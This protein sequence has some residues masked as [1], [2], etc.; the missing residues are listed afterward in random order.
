MT[1]LISHVLLYNRLILIAAVCGTLATGLGLCFVTPKYSAEAIV[2]VDSRRDKLADAESAVS[3]IVVDQYQT[4]LKSELAMITSPALARRV[5]ISLHLLETPEFK[6]AHTHTPTSHYF[7]SLRR[8]LVADMEWVLDAVGVTDE[9]I[10]RAAPQPSDI[11]PNDATLENGAKI[12]S[13]RLQAINDAKSLTLRISYES[14][15]PRLAAAVANAV[16]DGYLAE[17]REM[18]RA[19]SARSAAWLLKRITQ[20]RA[21]LETAEQAVEDFRAQHDLATRERAPLQDELLQLNSRRLDAEG[22]VS[23]AQAKVVQADPA[24]PNSLV[25]NVDV[26]NSRMVAGLLQLEAQLS[27][28]RAGMLAS[29]QTDSRMLDAINDQM[30]SIHGELNTQIDRYAQAN[31]AELHMARSRLVDINAQLAALQ[32]KI[33]VSNVADIKMR[34]LEQDAMAA[35]AVLDDLTK[36]YNQD[37]GD[38]LAEPDSRVVSRAN[39]PIDPVSP[40]YGLALLVGTLGFAGAAFGLSSVV[41]RMRRGVGSIQELGQITGLVVAGLT[42]MARGRLRARQMA[43]TAT[44]P[45]RD[46]AVTIRAFAR[47]S[48]DPPTVTTLLVTS[49]V[50]NEGKSTVALSLARSIANAG[51]RCLLIDADIRNPSLHTTLRVPATPGLVD[52]ILDATPVASAIRNLVNERFDLLPVGRPTPDT[53]APFENFDAVLTRLKQNYDVIILDSAPVLLASEGLVLSRY[54]DLTLFLV[55][56]RTTPREIARKAVMLLT[57]HTGGA[58]L[59]VLTQVSSTHLRRGEAGVEDRYRAAY[60]LSGGKP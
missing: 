3:G 22:Q 42:P 54:V 43:A 21:N 6:A 56:W 53:L 30:R 35:R 31:V 58:C 24:K 59:A 40:H 11:E 29:R 47:T 34:S 33:N 44:P 10:S 51:K 25:A 5:I 1:D 46:L 60:Q 39:V 14:V 37:A 26:L 15:D 49:T 27:A 57:R 23:A 7:I 13:K 28:Q 18:K 32:V 16:A 17:D 38:P 12:F 50:P 55:K 20:L 36:R 8:A 9:P 52:M 19:A 48:D 41:V 2:I 45:M 4:A